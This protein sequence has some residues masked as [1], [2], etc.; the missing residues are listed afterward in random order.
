MISWLVL[1]VVTGLLGFALGLA[2]VVAAT[3][4]LVA[5]TLLLAVVG[6]A[7]RPQRITAR[8]RRVET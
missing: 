4:I 1:L 6:W 3:K 5:I 2:P 8:P 7:H